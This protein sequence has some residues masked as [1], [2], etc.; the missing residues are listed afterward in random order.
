ME[1][2]SP[3]L[4]TTH[5]GRA[6]ALVH[7]EEMQGRIDY[8]R[9]FILS[10]SQL[11]KAESCKRKWWFSKVKRLP[12]LRKVPDPRTFGDIMHEVLNRYYSMDELGRG[13]DGKA[14]DLYPKGW[15]R[16]VSKFG[17][18]K[19]ETRQIGVADQALIKALIS[20]AREDGKIHKP[21]ES[22]CEHPFARELKHD[23]P[24]PEC[25]GQSQGCRECQGSGVVSVSYQPRMWIV[26]SI[27]LLHEAGIEDHK[28][29]KAKKWLLS[30]NKLLNDYQMNVYGNE[31]LFI[32][33]DKGLEPPASITLCHNGFVKDIENPLVKKTET[34]AGKCTPER[35][36]SM[37]TS[38]VLPLADDLHDL[39]YNKKPEHWT[40]VPSAEVGSKACEAYGGCPYKGICSGRY[41][42]QE[43]KEL[44]QRQN[45]NPSGCPKIDLVASAT[46]HS[47]TGANTMVDFAARLAAGASRPGGTG[48]PPAPAPQSRPKPRP[49]AATPPAAAKPQAVKGAPPWHTPGCVPCTNNPGFN[50][51]G[52]PCRICN[53]HSAKPGSGR[54]TSDKFY[55]E[56][57][58]GMIVWSDGEDEGEM[59]FVNDVQ[60]K[61]STAP[62]PVPEAPALIQDPPLADVPAEEPEDEAE[63]P[64]PEPKPPA[65]KRGR[66]RP[67]GAKNKPKTGAPA[68]KKLKAGGCTLLIDCVSVTP[69]QTVSLS[70]LIAELGK[71]AAEANNVDSYYLLDFYKRREAMNQAFEQLDLS[72]LTITASTASVEERE[73]LN[74][75][76]ARADYVIQG[77]R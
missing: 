8:Y 37:W 24:C 68:P 5:P 48:A 76:R 19:G 29:S 75:L 67:P 66:G 38:R 30:Q 49:K 18:D 47:G 46:Q 26:G 15:H 14:V 3:L 59:R 63:A 10:A 73:A 13:P 28:S 12:Q 58:D 44:I 39:R 77:V 23:Q 51:R 25:G 36:R 35:L 17:A 70:Q 69:Q 55:I 45:S 2:P 20:K 52:T 57:I 4:V 40:D 27:D 31:L 16:T 21:A 1:K 42:P 11:S 33:E 54:K 32:Y 7:N 22:R 62:A 6:Q 53:I 43:Y 72:T 61:S 34:K 71:K 50:S 64:T 60:T 56:A 9:D 41:E 74:V 65:K